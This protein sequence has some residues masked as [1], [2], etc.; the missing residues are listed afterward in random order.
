MRVLFDMGH[1]AHVHLFKN[2]IKKLTADGHEV[3]ITARDKEVTLAF[4][5]IIRP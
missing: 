2:I 5:E 4:T 3:K 1:P